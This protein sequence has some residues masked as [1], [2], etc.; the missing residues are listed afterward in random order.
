MDFFDERAATWDA[1]E[2]RVRRTRAVAQEM[3]SHLGDRTYH[4]GLEFGAGTGS[5]SL[6]LADRFDEIALVDTSRGMLDVAAGKVAAARPALT[7]RV[8]TLPLDLTAPGA[9]D[10]SGLAPVDVVF[11][12]MALHHVRDVDGL[13]RTFHDLLT[14]DG[15]VLVSDLEAEDGSYHAGHEGFDGHDGF[16]RDDLARRLGSVGFAVLS[17]RTVFVVR[18]GDDAREYPLF[19]AAARRLA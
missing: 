16:D 19:L 4:R 8:T 6:L 2:E 17:H 7:A 9:A 5:L 3:R 13:L 12:L 14:P 11:S 1:D 15:L 18:R 10:R